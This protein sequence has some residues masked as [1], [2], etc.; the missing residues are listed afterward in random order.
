MD[1]NNS[2]Y[3]LGYYG[4]DKRACLSAWQST[5]EELDIELTSSVENRVDIIF[6]HVAKT[7]KKSPY[8]LLEFLARENHQTPFEKIILDFQIKGDIASHIHSLKHR[9]SSINSESQRYKEFTKDNF[10]L[11]E[12][13]KGISISENNREELMIGDDVSDWYEYLKKHN[14]TSF[15]AYHLAIKDIEKVLPRKRAK[16]TARYF[17]TYSTQLNYDWMMNFRSF[18][19]I[20]QLRNDKHAQEEIHYIANTMLYCVENIEGNPLEYCLKAFNLKSDEK[21]ILQ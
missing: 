16:E 1:N 10:Y 13:W 17:L 6:N 12:D 19:N 9:I 7:K 11:P 8:E 14:E 4:S 15:K 21:Y 3:L 20:Q 5:T 18:V 2:V